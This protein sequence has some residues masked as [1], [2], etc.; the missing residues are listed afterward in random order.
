MSASDQ[1]SFTDYVQHMLERYRG[2]RITRF[3]YAGEIFWLKQPEKLTGVWRILKPQPKAAFAREL[4]TLSELNRKNAPVPQLM[5]FG[6]DFFVLK[7]GGVSIG[8]RLSDETLDATQKMQFVEDAAKALANLHQQGLIH[9]RPALR[10]MLWDNGKVLFIDF[11]SRESKAD[12]LSRKVR[13]SL[14]F[15]HSLGRTGELSDDEMKNCIEKYRTYCEK[16]V[17]QKTLATLRRYHWLY[18]FLLL[19]KSVAK[20]DLVAVYRMF[21][22]VPFD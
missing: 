20:R 4:R 8:S 14:I 9:G 21:E 2:E 11:E 18:R 13:D 12:L 5:L 19:F 7:D 16:D 17:W 6:E 22:N 3:D 1:L 10:D 15:I